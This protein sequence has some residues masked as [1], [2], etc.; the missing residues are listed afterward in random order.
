ME[1]LGP[2]VPLRQSDNQSCLTCCFLIYYSALFP[3]EEMDFSG[4]EKELYLNSFGLYRDYYPLAQAAS[5]TRKLANIKVEMFVDSQQFA[6]HLR[7]YNQEERV[8][9]KRRRID[10]STVLQQT[11][12]SPLILQVDALYLT[13]GA[14]FSSHAPHY[15]YLFRPTNNQISMVDPW[16]GK[17]EN[18]PQKKITDSLSGLKYVMLW[19]PIYFT[20]LRNETSL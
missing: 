11:K 18:S 6:K 20:V 17:I 15:I 2:P 8:K 12:K 3:G 16:I 7:S 13:D 9:V 4:L 5:F 19:S 1:R 10:A 14:A